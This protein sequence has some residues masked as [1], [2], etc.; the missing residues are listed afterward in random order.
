MGV[1]WAAEAELRW[2]LDP[3]GPN[4]AVSV[5]PTSHVGR[6]PVVGAVPSASEGRAPVAEAMPSTSDGSAS[7]ERAPEV[8]GVVI[9]V[10][11]PILVPPE[12]EQ[13]QGTDSSSLS[14]SPQEY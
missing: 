13:E 5:V 3:S 2:L 7:E 10:D 12:Q 1:M 11:A 8:E 4:P 9:D 6:V 14:V